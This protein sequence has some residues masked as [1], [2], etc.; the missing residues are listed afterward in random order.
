[1]AARLMQFKGAEAHAFGRRQRFVEDGE[2]ARRIAGPGFGLSQRNF[3]QP[4]E[5]QNVLL[6]KLLDAAAHVIEGVGGGAA[7]RS[8]PAL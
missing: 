1:M 3:E 6:A 7:R 4:V 5:H 2:G 8:R